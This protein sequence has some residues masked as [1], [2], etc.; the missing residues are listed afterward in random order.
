MPGGTSL[1]LAYTEGSSGPMPLAL[2]QKKEK[3]SSPFHSKGERQ[4]TERDL[5]SP[6]S[7]KSGVGYFYLQPI[8]SP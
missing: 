2:H 5:M 7:W 8:E 6:V 4:K 3:K 1:S